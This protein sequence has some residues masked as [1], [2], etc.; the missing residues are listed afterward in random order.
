MR[1]C[2]SETRTQ[3]SEHV[4]DINFEPTSNVVDVYVGYLRGKIDKVLGYSLIKTVRGHGYMLDPQIKA[5]KAES[6]RNTEKN[7]VTSSVV[8]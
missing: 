7:L 3:L 6:L 1:A 2:V 8:S 5:A 4:W